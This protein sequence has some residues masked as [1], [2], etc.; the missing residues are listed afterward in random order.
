MSNFDAYN[1]D[2]QAAITHLKEEGYVVIENLLDTNE[3]GALS[4]AVDRIFKQER[5]NPFNPSD[6]NDDE[7]DQSLRE[8]LINSYKISE[9][10]SERLMNRI[11]HTRKLTHDTPW[12]LPPDKMNKSFLHVPTL[13]DYDKSQ[14]IWNLPAKLQQSEKLIE[15]P[16]LLSLVSAM[17][18]EDCVLSDISATSIGPKSGGSGAWHIDAPLTQMPEPLPEIPLAVQ[19]AWIID[20]FTVDNGATHVVPKS[21]L[22]R[23]KPGWGYDDIENE[24]VLSAPAGSLAMWTSHTWHK[25]GENITNTPRRAILG[26]YIRSWIRPWSDFTR[27]LSPEQ[28]N[29]YSPTARYLLGY[30]AYPPNRG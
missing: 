11:K 13:F 2:E 15:H 23:K 6:I 3:I 4:K 7:D 29:Q 12:P 28:A 30:S 8:Y 16:I 21:H 18:D 20:D 27:V 22:S 25:S 24:I 14:R 10:E 17:L 26:Y 1:L 9:N 5:E 19:N